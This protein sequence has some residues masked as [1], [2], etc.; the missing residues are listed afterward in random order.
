[1]LPLTNSSQFQ[2]QGQGLTTGSNNGTKGTGEGKLSAFIYE[3]EAVEE[4][5]DVG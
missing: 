4:E 3:E 2:V 1:M 5:E